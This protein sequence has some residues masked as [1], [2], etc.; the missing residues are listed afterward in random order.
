MLEIIRN[1]KRIVQVFLLLITIPF[2]VWGLESYFRGG[3]SEDLAQIGKTRIGMNVFRE[4]L[5][6]EQDRLRREN[7]NANPADFDS[8]AMREMVL[9]S[10]INRYLLLLE[11]QKRGLNV[12]LAVQQMIAQAPDFQEDGVFSQE[13]YEAAM[14]ARRRSLLEFESELQENL[15]RQVLISAVF[16]ASF[17]PQTVTERI[18]A[19]QTETRDV[20]ENLITWSSLANR[21]EVAEEEV[22]QF[23]ESNHA[24][25]THPEQIQVEYVVLTQNMLGSKAKISEAD[26]HAWY[27][28]HKERFA[29]KQEERR[30]SHILL[31]TGEDADK[32]KIRAESLQLLAEVKKEP[33]RFA[34][35]ARTHSEDPGSASQGGDLG[36][37]ARQ[38]LVKPFADAAFTLQKGEISDLV[39]SEFGLH[40][41][42]VEDIRPGEYFPFAEARSQVEEAMREENVAGRFAEAAEN[43]ANLIYEESDSLKPAAGAYGLSIQKSGWLNRESRG[44][45]PIFNPKLIRAMFSD[46]VLK[47]GR[48][49]EVVEVQ[50]GVLAA[51][52]LLEYQPAFLLPIDEAQEA[53]TSRLREDKAQALAVAEGEAMLAE[54][55]EKDERGDWGKS[56]TVSRLDP[57]ALYPEALEAILK[58]E[59]DNL[60]A[61]AGVTLPGRGYALYRITRA[62]APTVEPELEK[63]LTEQVERFT[64]QNEVAA[65][66][67][68]LRQRYKVKINDGMIREKEQ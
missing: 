59:T 56:Q 51:A 14:A 47:N 68:A 8:E 48:N 35:L 40:I 18:I 7:P 67:A 15:L 24:L 2:A 41:I 21:I 20:Q 61:Y 19:L 64:A 53:I 50:P 11:A 57:G 12:R 26:L 45:E 27:E 10:L 60:P 29:K 30:L 5:R 38:M 17:T 13:R 37:M 33:G 16:D 4:A 36:F 32:E 55:R 42:R 66:L 39:E 28:N 49:T 6:S 52:R 44:Q 25:F 1:S 65:Y 54:A 63:L 9:D 43:F 46:E 62:D 22:K 31:I 34:E 58:V 23:Y 3:G